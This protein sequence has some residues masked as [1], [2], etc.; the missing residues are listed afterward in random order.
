MI[1]IFIILVS[2]IIYYTYKCSNKKESL[3][4]HFL[5]NYKPKKNVLI[6]SGGKSSFSVSRLCIL[7]ASATA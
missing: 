7:C 4:T 3:N 5:T 6:L 1:I 2:I